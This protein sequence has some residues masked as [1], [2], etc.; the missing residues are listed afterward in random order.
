MLDDDPG[1][2]VAVT[3]EH[4]RY[5]R[6]NGVNPREAALSVGWNPPFRIGWDDVACAMAHRLHVIRWGSVEQ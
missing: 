1:D 4:V 6:R 2:T 5:L 3:L